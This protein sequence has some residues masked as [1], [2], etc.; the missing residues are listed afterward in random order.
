[1][2]AVYRSL[3]ML[4]EGIGRTVAWLTLGMVLVQFALVMTRYV[5]SISS[6]YWQESIVYMHGLVITFGA[7]Y[8]LLHQGHVRVDIFYRTA[9]RRVKDIT[10]VLGCLIFLFPLCYVIWWSAHPNLVLSWPQVFWLSDGVVTMGDAARFQAGE[11]YHVIG[12]LWMQGGEGST[13]ASGIP[14]KWAL[15][16]TIAVMA[17][18]LALQTLS[19]LLKA[20]MRLAG[21]EVD[22]P[23]LDEESLD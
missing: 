20:S 15:K 18:L 21:Y 10:D 17:M 7:A 23:H 19:T 8:T 5:F 9:S 14:F 3:D 13:E 2:P 22:D 11:A 16:S 6:L 4:N 1:M 12:G